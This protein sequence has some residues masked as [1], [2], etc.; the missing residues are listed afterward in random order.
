MP[1]LGRCAPVYVAKPPKLANGPIRPQAG[2]GVLRHLGALLA[3][4]LML[5][6]SACDPAAPPGQSPP[7]PASPTTYPD[8]ASV[9]PRPALADTLAERHKI[10]AQLVG[11]RQDAEYR[12]AE[13]AYETGQAAAPPPPRPTAA[14]PTPAAPPAGRP[15]GDGAVAR[16][17]LD[18]S[19]SDIRDRG[20]LRQF[21][22][23]LDRDAP[24]PVGAQ[25]LAQA[26]GLAP[27]PAHAQPPSPWP[28]PG[29]LEYIGGYLRGVF[30]FGD[31]LP[32]RTTPL[33]PLGSARRFSSS[34]KRAR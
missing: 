26:V 12:A 31:E 1:N 7:L 16:A 20:K 21:M 28:Q 6:V 18:N 32:D 34:W 13:I 19:L 10:Q 25:T 23:R 17:Y 14:A 4:S 30:G 3:G 2:S 27:I 33:I 29:T 15:A 24:D 9:P 22:R 5:A 8:L 11:A